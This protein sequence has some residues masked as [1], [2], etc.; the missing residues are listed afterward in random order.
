MDSDQATKGRIGWP[1]RYPRCTGMRPGHKRYCEKHADLEVGHTHDIKRA[2][3]NPLYRTSRWREFSKQ[4]R[5]EHPVCEICYQ[6][7]S[8]LVHHI[9]PAS[10]CDDPYDQSNLQAACDKCHNRTRALEGREAKREKYGH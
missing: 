2:E 4:Y 3:V 7:P 6:R 5:R 1:C 10:K 9:I 8:E